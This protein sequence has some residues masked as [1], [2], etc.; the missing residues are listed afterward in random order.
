MN[1]ILLNFVP[2]LSV[3]GLPSYWA[4]ARFVFGNYFSIYRQTP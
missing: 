1:I 2:D 4:K 3:F